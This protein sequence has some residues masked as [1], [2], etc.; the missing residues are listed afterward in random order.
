[1]PRLKPLVKAFV[2]CG[3]VLFFGLLQFWYVL[4]YSFLDKGTSFNGDKFLMDCGLVFFSTALVAGFAIDF[5]CKDRKRIKSLGV[6]GLLYAFYPGLIL[7]LSVWVYSNCFLG[8]PDME[9][10]LSTQMIILFMSML[11]ALVLKTKLF[12]NLKG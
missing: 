6:I 12:A 5:F 7:C 1:M 11:Y 9:R 3:I 4:G 10:L 2:W 8:Q